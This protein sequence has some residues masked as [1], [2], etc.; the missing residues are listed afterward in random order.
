MEQGDLEFFEPRS[1]TMRLFS[2]AGGVVKRSEIQEGLGEGD[3]RSSANRD[4]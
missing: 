2:A 3:G 1:A 4:C